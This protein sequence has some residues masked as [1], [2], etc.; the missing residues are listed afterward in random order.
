MDITATGTSA[1]AG[2]ISIQWLLTASSSWKR[3]TVYRGLN[4]SVAA[5]MASRRC[6]V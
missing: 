6:L 1:G 4:R 5:A 2:P 3:N